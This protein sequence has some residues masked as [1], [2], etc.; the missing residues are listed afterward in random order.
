MHALLALTAY[1]FCL[2]MLLAAY[3]AV[4][5]VLILRDFSARQSAA[6]AGVRS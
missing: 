1:L 6:L 5:I 4:R 2:L 3:G